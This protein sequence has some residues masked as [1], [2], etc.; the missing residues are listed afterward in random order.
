MPWF[1]IFNYSPLLLEQN[2]SS[3]LD[4]KLI[5]KASSSFCNLSKELG[6]QIFDKDILV[7]FV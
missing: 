6:T 2:L 7:G 4:Y 5:N 1:K 3:S